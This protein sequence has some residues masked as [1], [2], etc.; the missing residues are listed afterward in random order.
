MKQNSIILATSLLVS[1]CFIGAGTHGK[2]ETYHL[3]YSNDQIVNSIDQFLLANPLYFSSAEDNGWIYIK[4]PPENNRFGFSI[5][6]QSE[7][8]LIAAGKENENA[9]WNKDL[10]SLEKKTFTN[11]FETHFIN[12]LRP[13]LTSGKIL[14]EPFILS[15]Q[16]ADTEL[17][18]NYIFE[19]DTLISYPLPSEL[20]SLGPSYFEDLVVSFT[21]HTGRDVQINQ[22]YNIFRIE[23]DYSGYISDSIY[24]TKRYRTIGRKNKTNTIFDGMQWIE[25]IDIKNRYNRIE[26]YK[27][28]RE[29]KADKGYSPTDVYSEFSEERWMHNNTHLVRKH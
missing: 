5:G 13:A 25:Y 1:S 19:S 14:K 8:V 4:I 12:K 3:P 23:Q 16:N 28:L 24:I 26:A 10:S 15:N 29:Q 11:D 17:W 20:D 6:G 18:P 27:K 9:K 7:I 2:I 22:Y 21:K